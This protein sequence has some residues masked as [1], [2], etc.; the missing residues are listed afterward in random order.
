MLFAIQTLRMQLGVSF[1][2]EDPAFNRAVRGTSGAALTRIRNRAIAI[3]LLI[4][5]GLLPYLLFA[6][7]YLTVIVNLSAQVAIV[8]LW[9][10]NNWSAMWQLAEKWRSYAILVGDVLFLA[11]VAL[12]WQ[13]G[14]TVGALNR[15]IS[16]A[17]GIATLYNMFVTYALSGVIIVL[18]G[19]VIVTYW[20][21]LCEA[22]GLF[23][24]TFKDAFHIEHEAR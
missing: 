14:Y 2:F 22:A 23:L 10:L 5:V 3:A 8:S 1:T 18:V 6:G 4:T 9:W 17:E 16:P 7:S 20:H 15:L 12:A 19:E 21:S 13:Y 11:A 24:Q